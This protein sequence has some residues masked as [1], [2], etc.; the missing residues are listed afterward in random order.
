MEPRSV[1][2]IWW[3]TC[4]STRCPRHLWR[5]R[6]S[7]SSV[8]FVLPVNSVIEKRMAPAASDQKTQFY[9]SAQPVVESPSSGISFCGRLA[10]FPTSA[11]EGRRPDPFLAVCVFPRMSFAGPGIVWNEWI[12]SLPS[13]LPF[14][15]CPCERCFRVF[16]EQHIARFREKTSCSKKSSC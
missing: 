4:S 3:P 15:M 6:A 1:L 8:A 13:M 14:W 16:T 11:F 9:N 10:S 7:G 5:H 2:L 12:G